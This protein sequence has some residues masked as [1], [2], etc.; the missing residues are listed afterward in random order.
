MGFVKFLFGIVAF[1]VAIW[2]LKIVLNIVGFFLY[3]IWI[4]T[5]VGFL[6]LVG[7]LIY[8]IL[9]PRHSIHT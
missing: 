4:A 9:V 6:L 3:L 7:Y 8:R 5:V 1:I 2:V